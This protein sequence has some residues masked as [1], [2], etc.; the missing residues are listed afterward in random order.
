[1]ALHPDLL[2]LT[3]DPKLTYNAHIQNI[4]THAQKPLQVIKALTSTTWGKQK[5][6]LMATY[7]A[8]MRPTLECASSIWSPVA[9]PTGTSTLNVMQ[10]AALRACTGCTH[11]TNI[12]HLHDETNILPIQKHLPCHACL[13]RLTIHCTVLTANE[14]YSFQQSPIYHKHSHR[15]MH[16]HYN[17]H[18]NNMRDI[19]TGIVSQHINAARDNNKILNTHPPQ[20]SSTEEN[21]PRHSTQLKTNKPLFNLSYLH[22][23]DASTHP[24]PLCPLCRTHEHTTQILFS[25]PQIRTTLSAL[26]LWRD[27]SGLAALLDD[28]REKLAAKPHKATETNSPPPP[29]PTTREE[30]VDNH[31]NT[32][33]YIQRR[34]ASITTIY[35][36]RCFTIN[37]QCKYKITESSHS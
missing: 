9:S 25:C 17:R 37:V 24:S 2:G 29:P 18:K 10:N 32:K 27:P 16:Y 15:P 8:V 3:L 19:H 30:W 12:Q 34:I 35:N 7:E 33:N 14:T 26:D 21:P 4:A 5:E 28:W 1:M 22:K 31:N 20:V 23:I 13:V 36:K 6:T 11:D